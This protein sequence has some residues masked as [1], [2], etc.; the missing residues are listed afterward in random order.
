MSLRQLFRSHLLP[1][2]KTLWIVVILQ[3]VPGRSRAM[4]LPSFNADIIDK[5]C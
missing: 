5:G 3:A 1:Y 4:T 2:R